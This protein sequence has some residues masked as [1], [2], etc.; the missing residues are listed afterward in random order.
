MVTYPNGK[1]YFQIG[2]WKGNLQI[3][4]QFR[5][6]KLA[7]FFFSSQHRELKFEIYFNFP[8]FGMWKVKYIFCSHLSGREKRNQNPFPTGKLS[9]SNAKVW[10]QYLCKISK[11]AQLKQIELNKKTEEY[12]KVLV[13]TLLKGML[14]GGVY[15]K[16]QNISDISG[17]FVTWWLPSVCH[18]K[19]KSIKDILASN[20][21]T[22]RDHLAALTIWQSLKATRARW[23]LLKNYMMRK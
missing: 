7:L 18:S 23:S 5:E 8:N 13:W 6:R 1:H 22:Y 3:T 21:P 17:Y 20:R 4:S 14:W 12:L 15:D 2:K 9:R 10:I 19:S 16:Y 11:G